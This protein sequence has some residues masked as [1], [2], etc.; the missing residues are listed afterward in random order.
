[1]SRKSKAAEFIEQGYDITVTGRNVQV[2]EAMKAYALEKVSKLDRFTDRIIDVVVTMDIQKLEHRVD[3]VMKVNHLKIKSSASSTD[4]YASIDKAV[5]KLEA[6]FRRYKDRLQDHQAIGHA[7]MEMNVNIVRSASLE[8]EVNDEIESENQRRLYESVKAGEIVSKEKRM[9]KT[10]TLDE[11]MMK[12]ELS[13]DHFLV[14]R[15]EEDRKLK[16]IYRRNDG[17]F[18]VIEAEA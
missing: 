7:L 6:Q 17:N 3:I 13:G 14:F 15:G 16:V 10:L 18:G 1:M 11:A 2:T 12:L 4:M 5:S 8:E 9:L